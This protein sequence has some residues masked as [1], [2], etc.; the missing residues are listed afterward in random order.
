MASAMKNTEIYHITK[1]M[2]PIQANAFFA[3]LS[4]ADL[5]AKRIP[6]GEQ[7]NGIFFF[8][9]RDAAQNHINFQQH[10]KSLYKHSNSNLYLI[11]AELTDQDIIFPNCQLDYEAVCDDMFNL[12]IKYATIQPIRFRYVR[13]H[14]IGNILHIQ[15]KTVFKKLRKFDPEHSGMIEQIATHLY[16]TNPEFQQEYNNLLHT[17][18]AGHGSDTTNFAIKLQNCPN[19]KKYTKVENTI[20]EIPPKI[21]QIDKWKQRY[22]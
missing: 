15:Y 14:T 22:K 4:F 18:I 13:A 8:T 21:S 2:T 10:E 5:M 17:I 20:D 3:S 9:T 16:K 11:T 1:P 19:I 7:S 6:L 12:F